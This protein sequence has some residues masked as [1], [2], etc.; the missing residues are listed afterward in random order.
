MNVCACECACMRIL[1]DATNQSIGLVEGLRKKQNRTSAKQCRRCATRNSQPLLQQDKRFGVH[2]GAWAIHVEVK[3]CHI[4][5]KNNR[6]YR[7][8]S[9]ITVYYPVYFGLA[10][11]SWLPR[12]NTADCGIGYVRWVGVGEWMEPNPCF[13]VKGTH[14]D[15][16]Q[17]G[18]IRSNA[19]PAFFFLC[20]I[21]IHYS[22]T[23]S[24]KQRTVRP[25][26]NSVFFHHRIQH[27]KRMPLG[28][29]NE[30]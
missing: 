27:T 14:F 18:S 30:R 13:N 11:L 23:N 25:C 28:W 5:L 12:Q 9:S 26:S 1:V 29:A 21:N 7:C 24:D 20:D 4:Q 15:F 3:S 19:R 2:Q 6:V 22:R 16:F 8:H 17:G 10:V